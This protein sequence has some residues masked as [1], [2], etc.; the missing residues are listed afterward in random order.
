MVARPELSWAASAAVGWGALPP[1]QGALRGSRA[2]SRGPISGV[3]PGGLA[4]PLPSWWNQNHLMTH[5]GFMVQTDPGCVC[6]IKTGQLKVANGS[7]DGTSQQFE[8]HHG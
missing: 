4:A 5:S 8:F 2:G 7:S 1:P 3:S 6:A